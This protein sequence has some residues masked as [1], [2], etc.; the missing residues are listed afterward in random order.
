MY[1]VFSF[2][3]FFLLPRLVLHR[4]SVAVREYRDR[5]CKDTERRVDDFEC[6]VYRLRRLG[7]RARDTAE[8]ETEACTDRWTYTGKVVVQFVHARVDERACV[9]GSAWV[10][11]VAQLCR[12]RR[13]RSHPFEYG[14]E[15]W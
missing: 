13:L 11:N 3:T 4:V 6:V 5:Q 9:I 10:E 2:A 1:L 14:V 8:A 12:A 15:G 7:N